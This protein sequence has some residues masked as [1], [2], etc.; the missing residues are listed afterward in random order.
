MPF[1]DM[2]HSIVQTLPTP[3]ERILLRMTRF[4]CTIYPALQNIH[5]PH[6]RNERNII[7]VDAL[8][9][10]DSFCSANTLYPMRE[11]II[12]KD[13]FFL[14]DLPYTPDHPSP[15]HTHNWINIIVV[16]A[17]FRYDSFY[18]ANTPHPRGENIIAN[19]TFFLYDLSYTPDHPSLI[20]VVEET[21]L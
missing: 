17:L 20:P 10:Y 9:R 3:V 19:D 21:S 4:S 13:T 15:P 5:P 8:F 16:D 1:S 14:H 12:A 7:I 6:T 11:N 18:S 2:I